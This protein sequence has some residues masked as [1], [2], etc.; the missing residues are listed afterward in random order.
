M[1][2]KELAI[3]KQLDNGTLYAAPSL[4]EKSCSFY[5]EEE[6]RLLLSYDKNGNVNGYIPVRCGEPDEDEEDRV[7]S[8]LLRCPPS[9]SAT[10]TPGAEH[11]LPKI[12]NETLYYMDE[13]VVA[14]FD[15]SNLVIGRHVPTAS[16]YCLELENYLSDMLGIK[17]D[18]VMKSALK[19]GIGSHILKEVRPL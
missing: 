7:Y 3:I 2:K 15:Y 9:I 4:I 6:T 5:D 1:N 8:Y 11:V 16:T 13:D 18:L 19:P 12:V 14:D 17:V 10:Y